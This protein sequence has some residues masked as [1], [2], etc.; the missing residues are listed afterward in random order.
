MKVISVASRK[1][2]VGKTTITYSLA[3]EA[4]RR[5]EGPIAL[6]DF[7]PSESL[8][9]WWK[10]RRAETPAFSRTLESGLLDTIAILQRRGFRYVFIDTGAGLDQTHADAMLAADLILIP[11]QP[12]PTDMRAVGGS[13][14]LAEKAGK[15]FLFVLSI[16][17][18]GAKLT[19]DAEGILRTFG[20][21][22]EARMHN[23]DIHREAN[24]AGY[25]AQEVDS[26][27]MAAGD[28]AALWSDVSARLR[29]ET[30]GA[31][32]KTPANV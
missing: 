1:G 21:V 23:Y 24:G 17:R 14:V 12:S 7:D 31:K 19:R 16:A 6:L 9:E 25:A 26:G 13:I 5:G 28:I 32:I 18:R 30:I 4:D 22:S 2:G 15:P 29:K 10:A 20:P 11:L 8:T 3:I 27:S